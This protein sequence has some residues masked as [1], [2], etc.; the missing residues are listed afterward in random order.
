MNSL[1]LMMSVLLEWVQLVLL[2]PLCCMEMNAPAH[3][4]VD[5]VQLVDV[6]PL[7]RPLMVAWLPRLEL[8]WSHTLRNKT[9][10]DRHHVSKKGY[11][12]QACS[13]VLTPFRF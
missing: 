1:M 6:V 12:K 8:Y 2:S 3:V 10:N 4:T 11:L 9:Q 5:V 13:V 7:A